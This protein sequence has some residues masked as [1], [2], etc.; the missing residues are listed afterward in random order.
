M[1]QYAYCALSTLS[2]FLCGEYCVDPLA[3][4]SDGS[5]GQQYL[6]TLNIIFR[7]SSCSYS[8]ILVDKPKLWLTLR[9]VRGLLQFLQITA[10]RLFPA[11]ALVA[12]VI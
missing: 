2:V 10:W 3:R 1:M 12:S 4:I 5:I 6:E 7:A 11:P 9:H 8:K